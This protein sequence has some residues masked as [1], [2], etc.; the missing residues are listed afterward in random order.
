M[1]HLVLAAFAAA[2]VVVSALPAPAHAAKVSRTYLINAAGN[3]NG[4]LPAF[5]TALRKRPTAITNEGASPAFVS[6]SLPGD[7]QNDGTELFFMAFTNTN[8]TPVTF[9]CTYVDGQA[10]GFSGSRFYPKSI[11][12]QASGPGFAQWV[13]SE[14]GQTIFRNYANVSC[15]LPPGVELN[16]VQTYFSEENGVSAGR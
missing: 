7:F 13:P 10:S 2:T 11:T 14:E 5:E 15:A 12:L 16:S 6:C 9:N 1:K 8:A 3:C 4:A